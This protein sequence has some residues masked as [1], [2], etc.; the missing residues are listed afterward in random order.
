MATCAAPRCRRKAK[1]VV[2]NAFVTAANGKKVCDSAVCW[3][4]LTGGYP[5]EGRAI[6]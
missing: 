1:W 5:A 6:Q 4:F 3:G 2:R